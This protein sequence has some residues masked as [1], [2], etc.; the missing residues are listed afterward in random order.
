M[1]E[2][3]GKT[4]ISYRRTRSAEIATLVQTFHEHGVP[5]WQDVKDLPNEPT[6][7]ELEKVLRSPETANAILFLTPD[8]ASSSTIQ[9]V[10]LPELLARHDKQEAFFL[11]PVAAGGLQREKAGDVAPASLG[12][13]SLASWNIERVSD[14]MSLGEAQAIARIVA[15]QR[16]QRVNKRLAAGEPFTL[17]LDVKGRVTGKWGLHLDWTKSHAIGVG[18]AVWAS[19]LLPALRTVAEEIGNDRPVLATGTPSL[20]AAFALGAAFLAPSRRQLSWRQ[21]LPDGAEETWSL[22]IP[23]A[24]SGFTAR[25]QQDDLDGTAIAL[26]IS[27]SDDVEPTFN[28]YKAG[29]R[30]RG[31]VRVRAPS[32]PARL[33]PSTAV[34]V[35]NLT[36]QAIREARAQWA[37]VERIDV[38]LGGPAGLAVLL[39]QLFNTLPPIQTFDLVHTGSAGSYEESAVIKPGL[40]A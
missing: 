22:T 18:H 12:I 29:R 14:P 24:D 19:R 2:V 40:A 37:H 28:L 16:I 38:F 34:H 35:A 27:A 17:C 21:R 6:N 1:T 3:F 30:Y 5:T 32:F 8:V 26:L 23:P 15:R 39:G 13:R 33:T 9:K 31:L 20:P 11:T 4:F 25:K 7:D 36:I 10:E